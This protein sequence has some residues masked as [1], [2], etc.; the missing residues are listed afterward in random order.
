MV[1]S[2]ALSTRVML[3]TGKM[4]ALPLACFLD[5]QLASGGWDSSRKAQT[6]GT[7]QIRG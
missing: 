7:F 2:F 3:P 4:T 6:L 5:V 1:T